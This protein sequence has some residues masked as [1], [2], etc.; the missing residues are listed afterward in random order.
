MVDGRGGERR[1]PTPPSLNRSGPTVRSA[2]I[3]LFAPFV[4]H[5][6][7]LRQAQKQLPVQKLIPQLAVEGLPS[8]HHVTSSGLDLPPV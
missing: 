6:P 7:C 1:G 8:C 4:Q 2:L 5:I 3:I